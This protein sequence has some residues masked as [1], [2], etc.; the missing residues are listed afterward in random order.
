MP[1]QEKVFPTTHL[2]E[3]LPSRP[4]YDGGINRAQLTASHSKQL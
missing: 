4:F 3:K 2:S 1:F